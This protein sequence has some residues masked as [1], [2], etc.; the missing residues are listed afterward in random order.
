[1]LA[2][3]DGD[4]LAA[5]RAGMPSALVSGAEDRS[6]GARPRCSGSDFVT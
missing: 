4:T 5:E 6:G 1:M 2:E 3:G